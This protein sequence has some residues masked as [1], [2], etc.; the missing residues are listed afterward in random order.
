MTLWIFCL[1]V[2]RFVQKY[3]QGAAAQAGAEARRV[4]QQWAAELGGRMDAALADAG[5]GSSPWW[6]AGAARRTWQGMR[7][8]R[9][10][11]VRALPHASPWR[12]ITAAGW[13]H[14]RAGAR[15]VWSAPRPQLSARRAVSAA[16]AGVAWL[17]AAG[18]V[19]AGPRRSRRR[20]TAMAACD[21]CNAVVARASLQPVPV[22]TAG[23][24]ELWLMCVPCAVAVRAGGDAP[25][26]DPGPEPETWDADQDPDDYREDGPDA[27]GP[28]AAELDGGDTGGCLGCGASVPHWV[29]YC[30]ACEPDVWEDG[31]DAAGNTELEPDVW[32]DTELEPDAEPGHGEV[33]TCMH[34]VPAPCGICDDGRSYSYGL[35]GTRMHHR[36]GS[37]AEAHAQA[38]GLSRWHETPMVVCAYPP[39]DPQPGR[40][41]AAYQLRQPVDPAAVE[42]AWPLELDR[43]ADAELTEDHPGPG[44]P[45]PDEA[46]TTEGDDDM[47]GSD[48]ARQGGESYTHG[49]W[50]DVTA[51]IAQALDELGPALENMLGSL[52]A[53]DAG[54]SQVTGVITLY[55]R[56]AAWAEQVR[57]MLADGTAREAPV[58]EAV[59][60]ARGPEEIAGIAYYEEV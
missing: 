12:R 25:D 42:T 20:E 32:E 49:Q 46:T 14:G 57:A 7:G 18:T 5:P 60:A 47:T 43:G 2:A 11:A 6:W 23:G 50:A 27:A 45:G 26:A 41:I 28:A 59:T 56:T 16:A 21:R 1:I 8:P 54:R 31:P 24:T 55:D 58:V 44:E 33:P 13:A 52:R 30:G 51:R 36:A 40:V 4:R 35:A 9:P 53:A 37:L 15:Q 29:S 48:L 34:G 10:G 38:R 17:L 39:G 22:Q 19:L 3:V